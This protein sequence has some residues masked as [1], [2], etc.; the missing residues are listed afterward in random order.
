MTKGD[1]VQVS[2]PGYATFQ[3]VFL[4]EVEALDGRR[5]SVVQFEWEGKQD[6][7]LF[8]SHHVES[9]M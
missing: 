8:P 6:F 7:E 9:L 2:A 3:G 4:M 5:L 1:L